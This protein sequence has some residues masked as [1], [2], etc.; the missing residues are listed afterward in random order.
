MY[1]LLGRTGL[2]AMNEAESKD[3]ANRVAWRPLLVAGGALAAG[4]AVVAGFDALGVPRAGL[5]AVALLTMFAAAA[6]L[7]GRASATAPPAA[8]SL[9]LGLAIAGRQLPLALILGAFGALFAL[10]L[11]G[12]VFV[13]GP[14]AGI[15]LATLLLVTTFARSGAT[16]VPEFV[17]LRYGGVWPRRLAAVVLTLTCVLI[18]AA[19]LTAVGHVASRLAGVSFELAVAAGAVLGLGLALSG[20][21]HGLRRMQAVL[22]SIVALVLVVIVMVVVTDRLGLPLGP[23]GYGAAVSEIAS[24]EQQLV[25]RALADARSLKPYLSAYLTHDM[26]NQLGIALA[27]M[28]GTAALS[29]AGG[30]AVPAASSTRGARRAHLTAFIIVALLLSALPALAALARLELLQ[31]VA[32]GTRLDALPGWLIEWGQLGVVRICGV[33]A[34]D[35][36]TVVAACRKIARHPGQLRLQDMALDA[37]LML[38]ALPRMTGLA[39]ALTVLLASG[40]TAALLASLPAALITG[41]QLWW[42]KEHG[43][44]RVP[45]VAVSS[46]AILAALI[47]SARPADILTL[48][49]WALALASAGLFPVLWLGVWWRRANTA[50]AIAGLLTGA[51]LVLLYVLG[52][53]YAA[54]Q[55]HTVFAGLAD[56]APAAQRRFADLQ[57]ALN[58]A[59][60]GPA[61]D[62]AAAA[63]DVHAQRIAGWYGVRGIAAALFALPTA[64]AA[65]VLVSLSTRAPS[66][67]IRRRMASWRKGR[68]T[69]D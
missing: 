65:L 40:L 33:A 13:L 16:S 57:Q 62:A 28:L 48:L 63:L 18:A 10:G 47:A 60:P 64:L 68:Q 11:D 59:A 42:P 39:F 67:D 7:V 53:R 32:K 4:T 37:E 30:Q 35:T 31:I 19:E 56:V 49:V 69:S 52:T 25:R 24:L 34:I 8:T 50:G 22:A 55:F 14:G 2:A 27:L 43:H 15:A 41:A 29:I 45:T 38:L 51:G 17:A 23:F 66:D 46:V 3:G 44:V 12:A 20:S 21:G 9:G 61:R 26:L 54:P 1:E 36:E 5:V 58:V 6:W